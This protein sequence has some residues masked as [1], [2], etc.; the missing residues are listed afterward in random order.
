[1]GNH[2]F[3]FGYMG[4]QKGTKRTMGGQKGTKRTMGGSKKNE[5]NNGNEKSNGRIKKERKKQW[6]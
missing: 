6:G 2:F 1:M 4:K 3:Y 5:I